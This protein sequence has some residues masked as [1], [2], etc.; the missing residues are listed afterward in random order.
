MLRS[1]SGT[2]WLLNKFQCLV[3]LEFHACHGVS[4]SYYFSY[5]L[6]HYPMYIWLLINWSMWSF[7]HASASSF[8]QSNLSL[9]SYLVAFF[10]QALP[11]T[12]LFVST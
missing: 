10:Q 4:L 11:G 7:K 5:I 3:V 2:Y 9:V 12:F 6:Y 8:A 1:L